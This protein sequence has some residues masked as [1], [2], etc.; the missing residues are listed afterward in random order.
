VTQVSAP[1]PHPLRR[2]LPIVLAGLVAAAFVAGGRIRADLGIEWS[3][4]AVR[5]W[6]AGLGLQAPL[7]FVG[8][9]TFRQFLLV[10][11]AV[12]LTAGGLLFGVGLGAI[13]GGAGIVLSASLLFWLAR[14][15]GDEWVRPRLHARFE[16]FERRAETAGP[17]LIG[18][19]TGHPMG[20]MTPF[21]LAAGV[22]GV[23]WLAFLAAVLVAGPIRAAAYSFLGANLLEVGSG[24][25]WIASALLV[26]LALLPLAHP[27]VRQRIFSG[28][29]RWRL[30]SGSA[31]ACRG[32]RR[33]RPRTPPAPG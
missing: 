12:L 15:M 33:V 7:V 19:M 30:S 17:M 20:M 13:L 27:R 26:V 5:F 10:P 23:S 29:R 22:S 9:V 1:R 25:F 4:E 6:V 24:R 8:L 16:A 3:A 31:P 2:A 11:S 21:H 28:S 18:L 14:A 32:P